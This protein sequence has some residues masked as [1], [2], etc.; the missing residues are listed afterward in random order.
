MPLEN[1]GQ[2]DFLHM[3]FS[4]GG[5]KIYRILPVHAGESFDSAPAWNLIQPI[6]IVSPELPERSQQTVAG[7]LN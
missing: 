1:P 5:V 2:I 4:V 3:A 7:A 6:Y